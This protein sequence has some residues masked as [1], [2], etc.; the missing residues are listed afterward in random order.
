M[1]KG[2]N[3]SHS[4]A[5][6]GYLIEKNGEKRY[7]D[8]RLYPLISGDNE[9]SVVRIEDVTDIRR[10][11]EQLR[12]AQKMET[13]GTLAGGLAHDFNNVL[14]GIV[15]TV[16]LI[17]HIMTKDNIISDKF[18]N[19]V[20][21]IDRSGKRA[22]E[23]V[24]QLLTLSR[25]YEAAIKPID[26]NTSV[27]NVIQICSNTFDKSVELIA[28]YAGEPAMINGDPSQVEQVII[29]LCVNA[30]HAMTIMR[31]PEEKEGGVLTVSVRHIRADRYFCSAHPEAR[32]GWYWMVSHNDTGVGM[33]E[34][35]LRKIF[36]PFFTTKV[37][38]QGTGLGLAMVYSIIHHHKGFIDVFSEKG[39]GSSFNLYFP[40][41]EEPE[42]LEPGGSEP[43]V[44]K[45]KGCILVIDDEEIVRLMAESILHECGYE[46]ILAESG[47]DGVELFRRL[48]KDINAVLLDMAMPGMSGKDVYIEL[49]KIDQ[50]VRVLLASGFRQD[51]RVDEALKLG[52]N[53]FIHKPYSLSELSKSIK[54]IVQAM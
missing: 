28:E 52:I 42:R 6:S 19:Y 11:D 25:K 44:V 33:D 17:R 41:S 53:G 37:R 26:L 27:K 15:G 7:Y 46:V 4:A 12:Q 32:T 21:I 30:A 1:S 48:Y 36:D 22:A 18:L 24:K 40:A 23:M 43:A 45:G 9:G 20:D 35:I 29:N 38:E 31:L 16:S 3:G 14:S 50:R 13:V 2:I 10:M 34:E 49:K 8:L 47:R 39:I 51:Y 5:V 54:E